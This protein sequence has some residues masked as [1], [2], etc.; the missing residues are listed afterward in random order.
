MPR[1]PYEAQDPKE[2]PPGTPQ[3][4]HNCLCWLEPLIRGI[5]DSSDLRSENF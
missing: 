3:L 1:P 2:R 5:D 4:A